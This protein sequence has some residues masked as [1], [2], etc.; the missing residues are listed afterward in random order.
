M[1]NLRSRQR[2]SE[3]VLGQSMTAAILCWVLLIG[4]AVSWSADWA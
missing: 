2:H 1:V 3:K 4:C